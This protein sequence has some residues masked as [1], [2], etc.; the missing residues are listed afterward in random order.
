MTANAG[1]THSNDHDIVSYML[2]GIA[3]RH[4][5]HISHFTYKRTLTIV[6]ESG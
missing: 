2:K 5:M 6:L 3:V 1:D 4:R